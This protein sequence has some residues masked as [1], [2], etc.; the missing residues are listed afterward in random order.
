M[1]MALTLSTVPAIYFKSVFVGLIC[2]VLDNTDWKKCVLTTVNNDPDLALTY[3]SAVKETAI[4][5]KI[6]VSYSV[7]HREARDQN[8]YPDW[9]WESST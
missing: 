2:S 5:Q 4:N 1:W 9:L 6:A 3:G 7:G 8:P